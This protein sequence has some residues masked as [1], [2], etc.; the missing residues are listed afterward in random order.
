MS[1][2]IAHL[3]LD[4]FYVGVELRRHP[5]LR[6]RPVV[7]GGQHR[8]VVLSAS[9]EARAL[10]IHSAM[11]TVTARR[12]CPEAVVLSPDMDAYVEASTAV[13]AILDTVTDVVESASIDE[14]YLDLTGALARVG[15][16][17]Q[18]CADLRRTIAAEQGL[19][20]SVGIGPNPFVAK[21]ASTR[22]KPDGL[23]SVPPTRAAGF[24][25][26]L[27][28]EA[29][30]GVGEATASTLHWLGLRTIG[31]LAALAPETLHRALGPRQGSVLAERARGIDPRR[32]SP[33]RPEE[34]ERSIGA[35]E[36]FTTDVYD[37]ETI[38]R[39]LLRLAERTAARMRRAQVV[40]RTLALRLRFANF[41]TLQRSMALG[42]ATDLSGEL[43]QRA[44]A[45]YDGLGLA[46]A[47]VRQV[48]IRVEGLAR[49][50]SVSTQPD[51]FAPDKGWREAT[52]AMDRANMRFGT[53]A[54]R[55]ASL[56]RPGPRG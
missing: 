25:A 30:W 3:D 45:L 20:C 56:T 11:P 31:D 10:G 22:A 24:L 28:V 15:S 17:E 4:A 1:R 48:G 55:R 33:R 39:E 47:R 13:F 54:V 35:Q 29:M 37:A 43:H 14:A 36:T 27:P 38:H 44:V 34:H 49:A 50:D 46:R 6:G 2:V 21:M 5:E 42:A 16:P 52:A 41:T 53:D 7:V 23:V 26:P 8:G 18:V 12:R 9:Y 19:A 32:L 51:L 40:G